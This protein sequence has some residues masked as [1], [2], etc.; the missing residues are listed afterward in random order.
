MHSEMAHCRKVDEQLNR[1][2]VVVQTKHLRF[3][4]NNSQST[5]PKIYI[6]LFFIILN[7]TNFSISKTCENLDIGQID[8]DGKITDQKCCQKQYVH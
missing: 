7:Q 6:K 8:M 5:N 3:K 1:K 2:K 4:I